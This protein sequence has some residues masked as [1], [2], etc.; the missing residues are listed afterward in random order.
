[1]RGKLIWHQVVL[2]GVL[3]FLTILRFFLGQNHF[4]IEVLW[5]WLGGVIG[6]LFVFA[7]RLVY[8]LASNSRETLSIQIKDLFGK[9]KLIQGLALAFSEREQQKHLV[10]RSALFVVIWAVLAIFT[11]TSV[12]GGFPRGLVLG[13]GTHLIFDLVWDYRGGS[14]DVELWFW[15]VKNVNKMEIDWFVRISAVF[16]FLLVWFL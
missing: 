15:Q 8:A 11:A 7:D 5:W 14:R 13:L 1:V 2:F 4:G 10:M 6:F 9:G 16:Y 12:G 3:A